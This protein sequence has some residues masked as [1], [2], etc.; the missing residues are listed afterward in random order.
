MKQKNQLCVSSEKKQFGQGFWVTHP[1][2]SMFT[3]VPIFNKMLQ[4]VP[5]Q[6]SALCS[7]HLKHFA[8]SVNLMHI[9]LKHFK[10]QTFVR[11]SCLSITWIFFQQ[12]TAERFIIISRIALWASK[13]N[14]GKITKESLIN[15]PKEQRWSWIEIYLLS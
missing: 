5:S 2:L 13:R 6:L 1:Q 14:Q 3:A 4:N 10:E 9:L 12:N 8:S 11:G 15:G 7:Q